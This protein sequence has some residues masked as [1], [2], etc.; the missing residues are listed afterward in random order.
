[1]SHLALLL[2]PCSR[3]VQVKVAQAFWF[4]HLVEDA[5]GGGVVEDPA[6]AGFA[7]LMAA[8]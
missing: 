1:M 6:A 2:W 4:E 3:F 7:Q 8:L 5:V